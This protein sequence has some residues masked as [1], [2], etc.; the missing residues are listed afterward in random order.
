[1][2]ITMVM[3]VVGDS[4]VQMIVHESHT[5]GEPG[6]RSIEKPCCAW[7]AAER[8]ISLNLVG[9]SDFSWYDRLAC[10]FGFNLFDPREVV[11][12]RNGL[13]WF[14][15][16]GYPSRSLQVDIWLFGTPVGFFSFYFSRSLRKDQNVIHL[17]LLI[18]IVL[19]NGLFVAGD[20]AH[21]TK[22]WYTFFIG[23]PR[24][25]IL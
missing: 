19:S 2:G 16:D 25:K 9:L 3:L 24:F 15:P 21:K 7:S 10:W 20:F 6:T 22:V 18:S 12:W 11:S 17:N 14:F 13:S 8:T 1:M 5:S 23:I 4:C